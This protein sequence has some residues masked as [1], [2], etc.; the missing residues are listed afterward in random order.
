MQK[1]A[2]I[3]D[4]ACDLDLNTL[5]ENNINLL[6]LRIIYSDGDYRDRLDISPQEVYDNLEKEVPKTSLPSAKET[7]E[8]LNRLEEE[9]YTHVICISISSG[10][11]GSFN[12]V[13]LAL[14]D[15]PKLTSFV[16]DSKIL[17]YPQGEIVLEVAKLIKEGKSY[18][19]I[20]KEIPEIRKRVIG[21]F[22]INTLE[23]LKRGGRIGR[24][25][26]TVGELLNLKPIITTDEDGVYY[27][28]A[29]VRGRKQS[30]SKMTELLKGYLAKN[31]CEIAILHAGCED[32]AIKYMNSLKD[33]TNIV[34]IKIA[35]ISP[36]L[37]IHGGPGLIGFSVKMVK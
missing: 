13:R 33:L 28:V 2:L 27:N 16:Y 4:S 1:I 31:K 21:Y 14:E 5:R 23:Y 19:E 35:E 32:E 30:L 26:G 12:S 18:E 29:K 24:L 22:T 7:E 17:A 36:A 6:P 37:G 10:L 25:A 15:H 3:T 9:G 11:S 34:S 20:I 8:V